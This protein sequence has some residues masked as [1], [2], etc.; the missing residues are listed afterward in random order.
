[1]Y[2]LLHIHALVTR[3]VPFSSVVSELVVLLPLLIFL[4]NQI[5][6]SQPF[7]YGWPQK[8]YF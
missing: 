1:M 7:S 4:N 6:K 2:V 5:K 8:L 3:P